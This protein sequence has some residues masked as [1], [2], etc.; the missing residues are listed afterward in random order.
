MSWEAIAAFIA[1]GLTVVTSVVLTMRGLAKI[2]LNIRN[3]FE[4]KQEAITIQ[5]NLK[6]DES[7]VLF[8]ETVKSV[9]EHADRAHR[10][11]EDLLIKHQQLELYIRDHYVSNPMFEATLSRI[12]KSI[13]GMDEK[14][15]QLMRRPS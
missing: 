15:D 7:R 14:I 10:K 8:G 13:E 4:R 11:N 9:R 1:L 3:Y 2:E 5:L 6:I 12:E